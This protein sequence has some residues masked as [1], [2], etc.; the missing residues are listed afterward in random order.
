MKALFLIGCGSFVGGVLR[1]AISRAIHSYSAQPLPWG[2]LLVNM[3]GCFALGLITAG[4]TRHY[5]LSEEWKLAL[6][7]GLCGG[8]TT[9]ST[10]AHET[11]RFLHDGAW[12][13]AICYA[14]ASFVLS[15]LG[16]IAGYYLAG[17]M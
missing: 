13:H 3:L 6:T 17:R 9:F 11:L 7:V 16:I 4:L 5:Q 1:Y 14:A 12:G 15:M 2:T 8:F 10:F